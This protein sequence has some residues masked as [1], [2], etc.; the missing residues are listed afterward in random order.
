[1]SR[2]RKL[3]K[4]NELATFQNVYQNFNIPESR[5]I[6]IGGKS[7]SLKGAWSTHFKNENPI[8]LELACGRGEYAI[9]MAID[10]TERNFV[11]VDIKG[12]RIWKGA[13]QAI[14]EKIE[15]VCF[16][17]TR[18]EF[19]DQF[20]EKSEVDEIWITFPDPFP[21]KSKANRRLIAP[22]FLDK[23]RKFL[24][25]DGL[26]NLKTDSILL[27]EYAL[28]VLN[29]DPSAEILYQSNDIYSA[30]LEFE[31]LNIKTRYELMHLSDGKNICFLQFR[32]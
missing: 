11:G 22:L 25:K 8:V 21:R 32:L 31:T 26:V 13:K 18:I 28:E 27:Y 14:H 2:R 30:P 5:L 9:E 15:N 20:F 16:L 17:R 4:F 23:Y 24:K 6:G 12:A 3:E 1:M 10:D 29:A 7:V 19:I